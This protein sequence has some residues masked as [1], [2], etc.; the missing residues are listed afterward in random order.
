MAITAFTELLRW[1]MPTQR[2]SLASLEPVILFDWHVH[3]CNKKGIELLNAKELASQLPSLSED[4]FEQLIALLSSVLGTIDAY[5]K[6]RGTEG[7]ILRRIRRQRCV[8]SDAIE[9][10]KRGYA[11]GAMPTEEERLSVANVHFQQPHHG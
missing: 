9:S 1:D 8:V 3:S 11:P 7:L 4:D 6:L 10:I 5:L 2:G